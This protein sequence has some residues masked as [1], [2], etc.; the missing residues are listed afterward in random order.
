[1]DQSGRSSRDRGKTAR[2]AFLGPGNARSPRRDR[3]GRERGTGRFSRRSLPERLAVRQDH[4]REGPAV[5]QRAGPEGCGGTEARR[6]LPETGHRLRERPPVRRRAGRAVRAAGESMTSEH[7]STP[8]STP[9]QSTIA[10]TVIRAYSVSFFPVSPC[11]R[12]SLLTL[13]HPQSPCQSV[14]LLLPPV[15][16]DERH[17]H[18]GNAR[19]R[20]HAGG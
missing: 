2:G 20:N 16:A 7:I 8:F 9:C 11:L 17:E 14:S 13:L 10:I 12:L 4:S 15:R 1:M 18:A 5:G 3:R 6:P 19:L